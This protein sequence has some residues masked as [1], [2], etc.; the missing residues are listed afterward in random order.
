M[1]NIEIKSHVLEIRSDSLNVVLN[2]VRKF[3]LNKVILGFLNQVFSKSEFNL[4]LFGES[5]VGLPIVDLAMASTVQDTQSP[6]DFL[7]KK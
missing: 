5:D 1:L 7:H 2:R 3:R 4:S 6:V